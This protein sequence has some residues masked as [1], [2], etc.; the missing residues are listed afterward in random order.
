MEMPTSQKAQM[1]IRGTPASRGIA[2]GRI[3]FL[4]RHADFVLLEEK[5][6]FPNKGQ[7]GFYMAKLEKQQDSL[8]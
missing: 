1:Q 6:I 2:F 7:D 3:S 4:K 8:L 5:T